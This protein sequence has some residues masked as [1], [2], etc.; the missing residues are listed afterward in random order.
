VEGTCAAGSLRQVRSVRGLAAGDPYLQ[1]AVSAGGRYLAFFG[2]QRTPAAPSKAG[3][4]NGPTPNSCRQ[5]I[6]KRSVSRFCPP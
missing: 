1:P 6:Q 5:L 3:A 4:G 2:V